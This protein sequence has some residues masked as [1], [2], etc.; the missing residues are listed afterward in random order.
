MAARANGQVELSHEEIEYLWRED[1][2]WPMQVDHVE[3]MKTLILENGA[4]ELIRRLCGAGFSI[5][6]SLGDEPGGEAKPDPSVPVD[7]AK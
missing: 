4:E 1:Y 6:H 5:R 3:A 7:G 2:G